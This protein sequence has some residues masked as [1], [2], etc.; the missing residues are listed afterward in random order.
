[1]FD[2]IVK[3]FFCLLIIAWNSNSFGRDFCQQSQQ[4]HETGT[5]EK[6]MGGFSQKQRL[7][8]AGV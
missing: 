3:L 6:D 4:R 5:S 8:K 1:M 7:G 2:V